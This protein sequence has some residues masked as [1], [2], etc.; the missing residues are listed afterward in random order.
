M[1]GSVTSTGSR[2]K[3]G[4]LLVTLHEPG[5]TDRVSASTAT[6]EVGAS[7]E[8][9]REE[10][11]NNG[12]GFDTSPASSESA[13]TE[14]SAKMV[15]KAKAGAKK[16]KSKLGVAATAEHGQHSPYALRIAVEVKAGTFYM[17]GSKSLPTQVIVSAV[18]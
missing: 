8:E 1:V 10:S 13:T 17:A 18:D 5:L 9:G 15:R 16:G 14:T 7:Q 4:D 11:S 3:R 12:N 2:S 6:K